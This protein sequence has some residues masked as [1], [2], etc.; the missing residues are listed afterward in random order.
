MCRR[1]TVI[2]SFPVDLNIKCHSLNYYSFNKL[3]V[4]YH[5]SLSGI[6]FFFFG[7]LL[8][9][10]MSITISSSNIDLQRLH[11]CPI[12]CFVPSDNNVGNLLVFS[13][14]NQCVHLNI[15]SLLNLSIPSQYRH[16]LFYQ[17][18]LPTYL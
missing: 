6:F 9:L 17:I 18:L 4:I 5:R 11:N 13:L 3:I 16:S 14:P 2:P 10:I 1:K 8:L 15:Y 12:L 7:E